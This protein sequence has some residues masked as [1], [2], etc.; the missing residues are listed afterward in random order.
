[1]RLPAGAAEGLAEIV[2]RRL[3]GETIAFGLTPYGEAWEFDGVKAQFDPPALIAAAARLAGDRALAGVEEI[4]DYDAY[5]YRNRRQGALD[6]ARRPP[7]S[8]IAVARRLRSV[9]PLIDG[10]R[11][12]TARLREV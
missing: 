5:Y 10:Q 9:S 3:G 2:W 6:R 1:M 11:N 12:C 7:G 8:D 4:A